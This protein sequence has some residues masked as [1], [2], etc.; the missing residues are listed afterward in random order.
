M[1]TQGE[2]K[3]CITHKIISNEK[4]KMYYQK[5]YDRSGEEIWTKLIKNMIKKA[6]ADDNYKSIEFE[7]FIMLF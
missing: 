1:E 6:D 4:V 5:L 3:Y 7:I 2:G